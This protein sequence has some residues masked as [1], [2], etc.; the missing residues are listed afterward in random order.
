M[1][2]SPSTVQKQIASLREELQGPQREVLDHA[3]RLIDDMQGQITG[4]RGM[5]GRAF[6][7]KSEKIAPGQMAMAF[8]S[9]LV[10][11]AQQDMAAAAQSPTP[12]PKPPP[13]AKRRSQLRLLPVVNK[14]VEIDAIERACG[15][16][17]DDRA[18]IGEEVTRRIVYEPARVFMLEE[19]R[20]K[21]ACRPCGSGIV[22]APAAPKLVAGSLAS[23]SILA[24]LVVSKVVDGIPIERIGRQLERHGAMLATATLNDWFGHAGSEVARLQPRLREALLS[25]E[26]VSLDDTPLPTK[27]LAHVRNIQR[28]RLWLYLADID[29]VAYCAFSPDWKGSHPQEVLGGFSGLIQNDG[30]AGINR[31]FAQGPSPPQRA[32]CNDHSRRKFVEALKLGDDRAKGVIDAYAK[33]YALERRATEL[34][35]STQERQQMRQRDA[36]P[37]WQQM[38]ADI[39]RLAIVANRKGPLGKAVTYWR[40]QRPAL[41]LYL[42]DGRLPIS[43]AHVE[44]LLRTVALLR[45]NALFMGSLAAGP[46]YAALLTMALNC[47]LCGANPFVYFTWLF[48]RLAEG[49]PASKTLELLPQHWMRTVSVS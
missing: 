41:E 24:H 8:I 17:G 33:L 5:V 47:T 35:S 2:M 46:R 12:A 30:Y 14:S 43:N 7:P 28:G 40:N 37:I 29:R 20:A 44:R 3:L 22:V 27:N 25:G 6:R 49:W 48:D 16:C 18:V 15:T 45:K 32:G 13:R 21:Y 1:V 34:N 38:A 10:L 23:S 9:H 11:Q 4:L 36:V 39:G 42:S 19:H 31:L 26:L